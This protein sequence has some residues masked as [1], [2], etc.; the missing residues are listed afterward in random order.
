MFHVHIHEEEEELLKVAKLRHKDAL[1]WVPHTIEAR[2]SDPAQHELPGPAI[3]LVA[4]AN[5][6]AAPERTKAHSELA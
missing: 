6:C 3:N 2:A 4:E 5:K 1:G